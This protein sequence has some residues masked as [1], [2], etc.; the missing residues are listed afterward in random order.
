MHENMPNRLKFN[1]VQSRICVC[2]SIQM[3]AQT[4]KPRA[5]H[6]TS[7]SKAQNLSKLTVFTY[8]CV[9]IYVCTHQYA[10]FSPQALSIAENCDRGT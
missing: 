4:H 6:F 7:S 1:T 3:H 10:H 5:C 2:K 8:E 9:N